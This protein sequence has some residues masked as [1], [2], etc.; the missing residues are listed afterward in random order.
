MNEAGALFAPP[1][2]L[3]FW[4][5]MGYVVVVLAGARVT[6]V[7]ARLHFERARRLAESGFRYDADT[8]HY[9]CPQGERLTLH[10]ID[11][12]DRVAVYRA[13]TSSCARCPDKV[14]CTPHAAGR[15]VYRPLAEWAETEVG[16]FHQ[17]LALIMAGATA[18]VCL[19]G[20][21]WW[22]SRPGA[23]LLAVVFVAAAAVFMYDAR[24][25]WNSA[26]RG[27]GK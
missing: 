11:R 18:V 15:H 22:A 10:V 13:P 8:D 16:R 20:L 21:A 17:G 3:E 4:L 6:E 12:V 2:D 5:L 23:G 7:V 14:A 1:T 25:V 27:Q 26:T 9:R 19:V 24:S